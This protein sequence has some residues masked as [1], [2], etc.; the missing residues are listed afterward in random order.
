[1]ITIDNISKSYGSIKSLSGINAKIGSGSIYGLIG[2]NGSGKSTLLRIMC[3]IMRPDNGKILYDGE[4]VYENAQIKE[5][6]VYLSDEQYFLPN[7]TVDEMAQLYASLYPGFSKI[8]Y[9][10]LIRLFGLDGSRKISTFSKG[11]K[12]QASILLG[13]SCYPKYLLCD[14]TFDGLDPVMRQFVKKLLAEEVVERGLTPVIASHNLREIED[15][16]DHIGLLHKGGILF[17]SEIDMLKAEIH[18]VQGVF[19]D[20][21]PIWQIFEGF[22]IVSENKRGSLTTAVIRGSREEIEQAAM[23]AKP[24]YF[25]II[26]L[27]LEEIFISEMEERGYDYSNILF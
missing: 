9:F 25:E 4:E 26:P 12:K 16:C 24:K 13:L 20:D 19:D 23:R 6:V 11:M 2:S 27:T 7:S 14:E 17:E 21:K 15:I 5:K 18:T 10:E 8:R 22:H 3:G 1:M